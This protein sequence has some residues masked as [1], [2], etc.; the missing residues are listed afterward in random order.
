MVKHPLLLL[1]LSLMLGL[2][3]SAPAAESFYIG[4]YTRPG[5]S[6]GIYRGELDPATGEVRLLGLAAESSNPSFLALHPSGR[7]VYAVNE[8]NH[9]TVSAFAIEAD[10]RLRELNRQSAR[11]SGTTHISLDHGGHNAL[12]ADYDS[13]GVAALP[14]HEDGTL[15]E[16]VGFLQPTGHGPKP[17][18][19]G[20]HGHSMY[21]DAA[22]RHVFSCDL[23][24][25]RVF[26][27]DFDPATAGLKEIVPATIKTAPGSGPRHLAIGPGEKFLYVLEEL[28][29]TIAVYAH[30]SGEKF[31]EVQTLSTL[32]PD[33]HGENT[34]AEIALHP[35]GRIL[36]CTNRGL[37]SIA[38]FSID[39]ESGKLKLLGQTPT[40]GKGPRF[41]TLDPTGHWLLAANEFGN[42]IVT[43]SVDAETG[44]LKATGHEMKC[45]EPVC[46]LFAPGEK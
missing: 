42:N 34:T 41:F 27:F 1:L 30:E 11:G 24:L 28:S 13:G 29:N 20:P 19:K 35:N 7:F 10:G 6:R 36:Y 40:G 14:I 12:V 23:G 17:E 5:K 39:P 22:D 18:Q 8:N 25:D 26:V 9:G 21:A 46:I 16:V 45:E 33:F 37:N 2:I 3:V 15:G 44:A 4:T 32:P 38:S 31:T 43:F